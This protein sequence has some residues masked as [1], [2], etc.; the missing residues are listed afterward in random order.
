MISEKVLEWI[1][2]D[3]TGELL[4]KPLFSERL[5]DKSHFYKPKPVSDKERLR[6]IELL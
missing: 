1:F 3:L 4:I 2:L 6:F 5:I